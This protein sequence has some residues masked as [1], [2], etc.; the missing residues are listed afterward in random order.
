MVDKTNEKKISVEIMKNYGHIT[1]LEFELKM[2]QQLEEERDFFLN[3]YISR[4]VDL[5]KPAY[6]QIFPRPA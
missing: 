4:I 3:M 1:G 5:I 6:F 2:H